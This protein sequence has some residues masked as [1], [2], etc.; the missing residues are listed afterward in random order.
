MPAG[1]AV[2]SPVLAG[3][4]RI[5]QYGK[6]LHEDPAAREAIAAT[7][8]LPPG[9]IHAGHLAELPLLVSGKPNH[10]ALRARAAEVLRIK[11]ERSKSAGQSLAEVRRLATRSAAVGPTDSFTSLGGDSL[12]YLQVQMALE[13]RLGHVPPGWENMELASLEALA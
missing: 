3:A 1:R 8:D 2:A 13:E 4:V 10:T 11:A 7:Y 5:C 12:S 6:T 9:E